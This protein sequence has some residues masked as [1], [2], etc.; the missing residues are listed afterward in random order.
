MAL[1]HAELQEQFPLL[2]P[3]TI[4]VVL[5]DC[6]DLGP[7]HVLSLLHEMQ[8]ADDGDFAELRISPA[9]VRAPQH[10]RI[11]EPLR[12]VVE[13]FEA[14]EVRVE[15]RGPAGSG[16]P[17]PRRA[18]VWAGLPPPYVFV[19]RAFGVYGVL[20]T[21]RGGEAPAGAVVAESPVY[22]YGLALDQ[23]V[24][25]VVWNWDGTWTEGLE[26][27]IMRLL[28]VMDDYFEALDRS[29]G[30]LLAAMSASSDPM[31]SHSGS[32]LTLL[33]VRTAPPESSCLLTCFGTWFCIQKFM[34][35]SQP[36]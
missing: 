21:G 23:C 15:L 33:Q 28:V 6:E 34:P 2:Q 3:D 32:S 12:I 4:Q 13:G 26:Q 30:P 16:G 10:V 1:S 20:A 29:F 18:V 19:P 35:G 25:A 31:L 5:E 11:N 22:R 17:A 27:C 7:S 24:D 9:E 36:K 8:Q 14:A